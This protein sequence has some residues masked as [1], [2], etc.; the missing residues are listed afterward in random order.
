[1][2]PRSPLRYAGGKTRAI[3]VIFHFIPRGTKTL[4]S[5]FLGGGSLELYCAS[6]GMTV[7]AFD[8]FKPLVEFWQCLLTNPMRLADI[9][10]KYYPLPKDK[11]YELQ[12]TQSNFTSKYE[13]A[14]VFFVLN[15]SS[16]SGTT[17]T[18]G[19]SPRH[20]RFTASSI[21]R[22]KLFKS[23]NLHVSQADFH[24]TI[25]KANDNLLYLDPPYLLNQ[26]LYGRNGDMHV[27][28]DHN[29]LAKLLHK[30]DNWILSY[31]NCPEI[32]KLYGSFDI[33]YP[34]WK[35]GMSNDKNS[36]EVLIISK[37]ISKQLPSRHCIL[38]T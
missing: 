24:A 26:K 18:G 10:R 33:R 29:G 34:E 28:F 20:P 15:R 35:Y 5:P 38:N 14:A 4:Y 25:P 22:L 23:K 21:E 1:M 16:F 17:M 6:M 8:N 32:H 19:M 37:N 13:R 11:F 36:R 9:V 31:N 3:E 2:Q 12:K 27:G 7:Y 30:Y